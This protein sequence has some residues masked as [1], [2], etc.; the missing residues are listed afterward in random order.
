MKDLKTSQ[1]NKIKE[2]IQVEIFYLFINKFGKINQ[3]KNDFLL[4]CL[5]CYCTQCSVM[6]KIELLTWTGDVF[7]W[8]KEPLLP[9]SKPGQHQ[10]QAAPEEVGAGR[11]QVWRDIQSLYDSSRS[12]VQILRNKFH[13]PGRHTL[14]QLSCLFC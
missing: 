14:H 10:Q 12:C 3:V 6:L 4:F 11:G 2:L 5:Q 7:G 8:W 13:V 1:R 9:T